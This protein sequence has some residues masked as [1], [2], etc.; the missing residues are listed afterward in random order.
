MRSLKKFTDLIHRGTST[1]LEAPKSFQQLP[2]QMSLKV[3]TVHLS[4]TVSEGN[5]Y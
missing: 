3:A 2:F 5:M 4:V 1:V